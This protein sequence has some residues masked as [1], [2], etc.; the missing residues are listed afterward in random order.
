MQV[1]SNLVNTETDGAI[2]TYRKW[3]INIKRVEFWENVRTF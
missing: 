2:E 3:R 1:K